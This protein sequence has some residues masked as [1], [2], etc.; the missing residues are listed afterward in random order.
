[1]SLQGS[2]FDGMED[3]GV[4]CCEVLDVSD[5]HFVN[6]RQQL[7][8]QEINFAFNYVFKSFSKDSPLGIKCKY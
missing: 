5:H 6:T 8:P 7:N 1:M 3:P 2:L 4:R